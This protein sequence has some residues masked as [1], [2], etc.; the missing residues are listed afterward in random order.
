MQYQPRPYFSLDVECVAVGPGHNDRSIA[1]IAIVNEY[2]EIVLNAYVRP[3][4]PV[5]S[6]L[7]ALTGI[8]KE[9]LDQYGIALPQ[10]LAMVKS[11]LP[12]NAVLVGQNIGT[13]TKWCNLQEGSDFHSLIDLV[14]VWRVFNPKYKTFSLFS[15]QHECKVVLGTDEKMHNACA[16]A[17]LSIRLYNRYRQLEQNPAELKTVQDALLAEEPAAS[18]AKRNPAYEGVCMGNKKT[19]TCGQPFYY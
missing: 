5:T 16:D 4:R 9:Q 19:C 1:Q 2:E 7:T 11:I 14:G 15:L 12:H 10:V 6:Y 17:I 18:F 8:T 13:D 3:D